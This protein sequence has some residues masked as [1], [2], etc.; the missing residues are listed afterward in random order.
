MNYLVFSLGVSQNQLDLMPTFVRK[1]HLW[2]GGTR[3]GWLPVSLEQVSSEGIFLAHLPQSTVRPEALEAQKCD[4]A[5]NL[6][7]IYMDINQV[8]RDCYINLDVSCI[9]L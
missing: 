2:S 8:P 9:N 4:L 7:Y 6:E 1:M 3:K 5:A